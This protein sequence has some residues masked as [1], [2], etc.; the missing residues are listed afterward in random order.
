[1]NRLYDLSRR[2]DDLL[3]RYSDMIHERWVIIILIWLLL[4]GP[5][6]LLFLYMILFGYSAYKYC[7][8]KQYIPSALECL[9]TVMIV[10]P[11]FYFLYQY[12]QKA[13]VLSQ[14]LTQFYK[15]I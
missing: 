8:E 7:L 2:Y 10:S 15:S 12:V 14:E 5:V 1:M 13:L 4:L 6:F 9:F 3:S 11:L